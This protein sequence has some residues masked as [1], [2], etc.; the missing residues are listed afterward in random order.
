M[1]KISIYNSFIKDNKNKRE[2]I[3]NK[4][5]A[6]GFQTSRDGELLIVIGGDGTFLSAVR[7]RIEDNPI[8]V[9]FNAG[10]LGFMSEFTLDNL[11]EFIHI[12][13]KGDYWIQT[14]PVYEIVM[15]DDNE[16]KIEYFINDLVV[17]R[18]S[19]RILHMSVQLNNKKLCSVSG[20][21]IIISSS[22]GST[23]YAMNTNGALILD[24]EQLLQLSPI[25]PVHSKAYQSISNSLIFSNRN[26]LTIFPSVKKQRAFRIVCDGKEIKT[27]DVR[28]LEVR[29]SKKVIRVL[30]S[31]KFTNVDNI[32]NKLL[33]FE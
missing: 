18:K 3:A 32:K 9:G 15:K 11:D 13:K 10:N 30:R 2:V 28:F 4:L 33:D 31:K 16:E 23:G 20:D 8:F 22:I 7:K 21:G 12:L 27:K 24:N 6:S 14:L 26:S 1:K 25:A 17:E 29:K 19:T 5:K